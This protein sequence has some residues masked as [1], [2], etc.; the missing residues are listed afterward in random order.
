MGKFMK[1][2]KVVMVLAGRY[3]GR[4]AVI[5][6]VLF[7]FHSIKEKMFEYNTLSVCILTVLCCVGLFRTL[8]MAPRTVLTATLWSQASIAILVKSPQPW[9]RRRL[10]RGPRSRHLWR[11]STTTIW[12]QPGM[13]SLNSQR[14]RINSGS[15]L[16]LTNVFRGNICCLLTQVLLRSPRLNLFDQ[17]C[18]KNVNIVKYC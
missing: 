7:M 2:G 6:K 12:C 9:A 14:A 18:S 8:M 15:L 17:K 4:K 5:V 11:C 1:P 3:A 16:L 13:Q 10:P